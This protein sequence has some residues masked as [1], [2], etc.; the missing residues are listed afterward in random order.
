MILHM[1]SATPSRQASAASAAGRRRMQG[2]SRQAQ[3]P[4]RDPPGVP[5]A[6]G[7][8]RTP[9]QPAAGPGSAGSIRT[10]MHRAWTQ[11]E[12]LDS[13]LPPGTS[14]GALHGMPAPHRGCQAEPGR[15]QTR[16]GRAGPGAPRRAPVGQGRGLIKGCKQGKGLPSVG[17]GRLAS[18]FS[19]P[20]C[21]D[22]QQRSRTRTRT[23]RQGL[24]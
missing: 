17:R 12:E 8:R 23:A 7:D 9:S 22:T 21:S 20:P 1:I 14:G 11:P 13:H 5:R 10:G 4:P 18:G 15:R 3:A 2:G 19:M 6:H 16:P 24:P